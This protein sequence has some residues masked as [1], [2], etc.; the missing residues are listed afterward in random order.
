MKT[1]PPKLLG[2]CLL[3]TAAVSFTP[4]VSAANTLIDFEFDE[5][6]GTKVTDRINSLIGAPSNPANPPTFVTDSPSGKTGDSAIHFEAGQYMTVND[7]DTRVRLN[8]NNPAFTLQAWV[9]FPGQP[10]GRQVFFYS[11]GPGGAISFSVNTDRTVFVTTLGIADVR[12]QAAIP[13]DGAWHHIAV[14]HENGKELRFYVD[15][16]LGDTVAYTSG[17]NFTRTQTLFSIGAEWNG[18]LQ[19]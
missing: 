18:A 14:V 16:I 3:A 19:Y 11:N 13:D 17:V 5:G 4:T 15:G 12:S 10:A 2:L 6:T 8:P 9:K 1:Y 7:P